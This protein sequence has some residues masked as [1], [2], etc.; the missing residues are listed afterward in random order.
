MLTDLSAELLRL[1]SEIDAALE[2]ASR[3]FA[4]I[5]GKWLQRREQVQLAYEN[6]LRELQRSRI[7][8]EEFIRLQRQIEELRPLTDRETLLTKNLQDYEAQRRNLLAEWEEVKAREFRE[9]QKAAQNV[10]RQ[11]EGRVLVKVAF[12]G[13]REPLFSLLRNQVG[14]RLS[15]AIEILRTREQLSLAELAEAIRAGGGQVEQKFG[16]PRSQAD[17]LSQASPDVVM[18]I[19]ELDLAPTT[20]IRLNVA[21]DGQPHQ[22]QLLDDLSTGQKATAV[23]LLLLLES[24]APLVVDQPEDDLDNRFITDG[25]VP[26]MREGKRRRQFVFSTHNANVPVLGDA[27][28]IVGLVAKGEAGRGHAE[29]PA[30]RLGS[31]DSAGAREFAEEILEGG[32][33]AFELRRLKYGF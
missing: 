16:V 33:D 17:R 24:S 27:E 23:L 21:G 10:S 8:G 31:I 25:V 11:L 28:L 14:G 9:L 29:I 18:Q 30:E 1:V 15:E 20:E 2:G 4:A 22:W 19:E 5:R 3:R 13:D 7:D 6:I 32:K 26:K 12:A